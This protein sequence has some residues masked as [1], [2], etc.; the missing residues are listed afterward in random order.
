MSI[1]KII[2][3][4]FRLILNS[5]T[6]LKLKI[7]VIKLQ[8][9]RKDIREIEGA[10]EYLEKCVT[11]KLE[12]NYSYNDIVPE[13]ILHQVQ[14]ELD[15]I[16]DNHI[17]T[18][19]I[20]ASRIMRYAIGK[21]IIEFDYI[22]WRNINVSAK[23][24]IDTKWT[25]YFMGITDYYTLPLHYLC[26][27]CNYSD[28]ENIEKV[29]MGKELPKRLCPNCQKELEQL[30][31]L[32]TPQKRIEIIDVMNDA[33]IELTFPIKSRQDILF[34]ANCLVGKENRNYTGVKIYFK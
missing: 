22:S 13:N 28:F 6:I 10:Y 17:A 25:A 24:N 12:R 8:N 34:Y 19:F 23:I 9:E 32:P 20:F 3:T 11:D 21:D 7:K 4:I 16:K 14:K 30:G 31:S 15:F 29:T 26:S 27:N 5:A 2:E 18:V 33:I 1:S